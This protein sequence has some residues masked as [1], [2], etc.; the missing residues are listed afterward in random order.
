MY[1]FGQ[2]MC[3]YACDKYDFVLISLCLYKQ[4]K[5]KVDTFCLFHIPLYFILN[6]VITEK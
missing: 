5:I 1:S 4:M 2:T 6:G 3:P